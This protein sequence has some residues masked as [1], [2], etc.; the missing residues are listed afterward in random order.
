VDLTGYVVLP[1]IICAELF[2]SFA[3][4]CGN[5]LDVLEVILRASASSFLLVVIKMLSDAVT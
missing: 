1:L 2:F 4:E 5:N 3:L